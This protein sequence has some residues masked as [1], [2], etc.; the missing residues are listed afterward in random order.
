V[1][2][3]ARQ[4]SARNAVLNCEA[5]PVTIRRIAA[6]TGLSPSR[7]S[8]L[9]KQEYGLSLKALVDASR[10]DIAARRLHHSTMSIKEVAEPMGFESPQAFYR[11][12]R[13]AKGVCP[14]ELRRRTTVP[15]GAVGAQ[16]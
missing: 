3:F 13:Q 9:F 8:H 11:F 7:L 4:R 6:Q 14:R 12:F 16:R 15:A 2:R 10:A 5:W 1:W